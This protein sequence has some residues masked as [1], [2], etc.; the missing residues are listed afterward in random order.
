MILEIKTIM[1]D[2]I[3][4][5]THIKL[6]VLKD[7][8]FLYEIEDPLDY[9]NSEIYYYNNSFYLNPK[10]VDIHLIENSKIIYDKEVYKIIGKG[11]KI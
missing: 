5:I 10:Q 9:K 8:L 1:D 3:H 7:I 11:I 4:K 2:K 6:N